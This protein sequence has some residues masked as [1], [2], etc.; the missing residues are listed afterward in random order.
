MIAALF[1][2]E[3]KGEAG[4]AVA[5]K[6]KTALKQVHW[7]RE[8]DSIL[9]VLLSD[10]CCPGNYTDEQPEQKSECPTKR[11]GD[12]TYHMQCLRVRPSRFGQSCPLALRH[13]YGIS[14]SLSLVRPF[15][16]PHRDSCMSG[17]SASL[18]CR[19]PTNKP[20]EL[21]LA[22]NEKTSR[23]L[24]TRGTRSPK[25]KRFRNKL[26]AQYSAPARVQ[27]HKHNFGALCGCLFKQSGQLFITFQILSCACTFPTASFGL[28]L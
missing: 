26:T 24:S 10:S 9:L 2:S 14:L 28:S 27:Y 17:G 3:I 12:I 25:A 8:R 22:L 23:T 5:V 18:A 13:R 11:S 1:C 21:E 7:T 15:Q 19:E 4:T 6:G 16:A 20:Q